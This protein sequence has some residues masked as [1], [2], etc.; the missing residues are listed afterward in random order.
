MPCH[1]VRSIP[2]FPADFPLDTPYLHQALAEHNAL[3]VDA[4]LPIQ[5]YIELSI[6][7]RHDVLS[8]ANKIKLASRYN[9]IYLERQRQAAAAPPAPTPERVMAVSRPTVDSAHFGVLGSFLMLISIL[10]LLG[11]LVGFLK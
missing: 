4:G 6:A 3:R 2:S 9:S 11:L 5:D 7:E 8:R 10:G 1:D